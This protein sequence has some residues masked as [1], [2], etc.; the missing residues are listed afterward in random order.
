M[1]AIMLPKM[2][3]Q[4]VLSIQLKGKVNELYRS[5]NISETNS[6]NDI[7]SMRELIKEGF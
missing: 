3:L 6:G 1:L 4:V 5:Y 2:L 7:G